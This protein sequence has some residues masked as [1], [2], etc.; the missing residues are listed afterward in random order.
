MSRETKILNGEKFNEIYDRL[1]SKLK[2][3]TPI[4]VLCGPA[5]C[6]DGVCECCDQEK[7]DVC[8]YYERMVLKECLRAENCVPV[9]FEEDFDLVI[10]SLEETIILHDSE[11][12][13]VVI[14]PASEGSAAELAQFARDPIVRSKLI[15][16]VP[17]QFHPW[18]SDSTSF[19]T[20]L[21]EEIMGVVG[22]VY[23][24]DRAGK[25][26][27]TA[28]LIL[29]TLMRSYRLNKLANTYS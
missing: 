8:Y 19:L 7:R 28:S 12:E 26:H 16:L 22:H 20:S 2:T 13:K 11:V 25:R 24:Y 10:A 4:V 23:P 21:Y 27:P 15:V 5:K 18:Y 6:D 9:L 17:F 3:D 29:T 14:I 1:Q